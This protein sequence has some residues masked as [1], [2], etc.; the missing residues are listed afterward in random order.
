MVASTPLHRAVVA[1]IGP[2]AVGGVEIG[3]CC[4]W[5]VRWGLGGDRGHIRGAVV[6]WVW[7]LRRTRHRGGVAHGTAERGVDVAG[8]TVGHRTAWRQVQGPNR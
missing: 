3:R 6:A 5:W 2:P 7:V 1:V 4:G 8:R